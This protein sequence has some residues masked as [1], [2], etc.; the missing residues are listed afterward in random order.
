MPI[1][2]RWCDSVLCCDPVWEDAYRRFESPEEEI[3]KFRQRLLSVGAKTWPAGSSVL[4]LCCGRGNGLRALSSLGFESLS[5]VDLSEPLLASYDG[6][7]RL[8]LGDCRDLKLPD[9]SVDIVIVQGGLHHLPELPSDL[10][11]TL[12][13]VRRILRTDGRLVLIEPWN[14]PFLKM[15]HGVCDVGVARRAWKKL[16][17]LATMIDRERTTYEGWLGR[18]PEIRELLRRYFQPQRDAAAWGKLVFVGTPR[19]G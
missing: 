9:R 3:S 19:H 8:F 6:P 18:G 15:V 14:T 1:A 11:R 16:D 10:E 7:A 13:E 5:G 4:E 12:R 17:A 2:A